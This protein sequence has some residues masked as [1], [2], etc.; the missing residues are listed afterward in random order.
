MQ[1]R[2]IMKKENLECASPED[3]SEE[4][5]RRMR[6]ENIGFLPVCDESGKVLGTL[7]DRDIA[8]REVATGKPP[9]TPVDEIM[10]RQV[11]SCRPED[12]V[13]QAMRLM[14][15]HHKSRIVCIDDIGR[16]AGII[17][18]SD[19]AQE[20]PSEDGP[21]EDASS[22]DPSGEGISSDEV[23][24]TLRGVTDREANA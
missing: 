9:S 23:A 17:S 3:T 18:L 14:V 7:T 6:D 15:Q 13:E 2:E 12:D 5:A 8:I 4:A 24:E 21:G 20:A 16:L 11:V 19:I 10:T 22:E 1:C